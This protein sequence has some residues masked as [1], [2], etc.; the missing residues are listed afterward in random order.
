MRIH[1]QLS[2][3]QEVVPFN[4]QSQVVGRMHKWLGEN[5]WHDQTSLYS[6]SWL[7]GGKASKKGLD[8]KKG[9]SW[10]ISA[11]DQSMLKALVSGIQDQP[12]LAWGMM[13]RQITIQDTP[14]FG[15][16]EYFRVGSPVFVKEKA[17]DKIHFYRYSDT[18]A[19]GLLTQTLH[20]KL[21]R[22]GLSS[23]GA[24]VSFDRDYLRP[25]TKKV[26]YKG[27]DNI[28]NF[29]PVIVQG[30]PEQIAFAWNVGVGNST[31]I[32]FGSLI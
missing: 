11:F 8:F 9:S 12:E 6:F 30:T 17:G 26:T 19:D 2:P 29:C 18:K 31:G 16:R 27:I 14:S 24:S 25:K 5:E 20:T 22:A 21:Q 15:E 7:S 23:D 4:Y 10:F 28:A 1:L 32:G 13:V 3:N